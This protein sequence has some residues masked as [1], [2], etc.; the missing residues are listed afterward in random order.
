MVATLRMKINM[1]IWA[2]LYKS[3]WESFVT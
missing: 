2:A 3:E 1:N